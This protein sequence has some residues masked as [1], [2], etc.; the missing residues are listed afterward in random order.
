MT[1]ILISNINIK[2]VLSFNGDTTFVSNRISVIKSQ[3]HIIFINREK[4]NKGFTSLSPFR[5]LILTDAY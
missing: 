3:T 4:G 2:H 5:F 1:R